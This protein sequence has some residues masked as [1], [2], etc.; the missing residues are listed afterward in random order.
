[1]RGA[2]AGAAPW[3][4]IRGPRGSAR[5]GGRGWLGRRGC[6]GRAPPSLGRLFR[7]AGESR[8]CDAKRDE[9]VGYGKD[10]TARQPGCCRRERSAAPAP[11]LAPAASRPPVYF[12]W[13]RAVQSNRLPAVPRAGGSVAG[14]EPPVLPRPQTFFPRTRTPSGLHVLRLLS[15]L[16]RKSLLSPLAAYADEPGYCQ[17]RFGAASGP[18]RAYHERGGRGAVRP[19]GMDA[20]G[21]FGYSPRRAGRPPAG[22]RAE[23]PFPEAE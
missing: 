11:L 8:A 20:A 18:C 19:V 4:V 17:D 22:R 2:A 12:I 3:G 21:R 7:L 1:M 16:A 10:N 5:P 15:V 13:G 14:A 9:G 23:A 6:K